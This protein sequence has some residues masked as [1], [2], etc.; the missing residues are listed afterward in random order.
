MGGGGFDGDFLSSS[1]FRWEWLRRWFEVWPSEK[2]ENV[3]SGFADG[4]LIQGALIGSQR[5]A[6]CYDELYPYRLIPLK[7]RMLTRMRH[8]RMRMYPIY[9]HLSL[10]RRGRR[11]NATFLELWCFSSSLTLISYRGSIIEIWS[12]GEYLHSSLTILPY[13]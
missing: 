3:C 5:C 4:S 10:L 9:R 2:L 6:Y 1:V 8:L 11:G 13:Y 7:T 12:F